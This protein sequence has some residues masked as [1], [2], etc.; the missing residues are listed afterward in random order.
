MRNKTKN[1]LIILTMVLVLFACAISL[2]FDMFTGGVR[3]QDNGEPT[4]IGGEIKEEYILGD[5][6]EIPAAKIVYGEETKDAEI[7]VIKPDGERI[8]SA[9]VKLTEGGLYTAEFKALFGGKAKTVNKSFT[10][11]IPLFSKMSAK[12]TWEYGIDDSDYQTGKEG[13]KVRL[14][15]ADILTY[16]EIIDLKKSDGQI[17]DFFLL[18]SGGIGTKDVKRLVVTLTDLYDPSVALKIIIQCAN[19]HGD[20]TNW[21]YDWTYVLA[22][23]Q[24]QTPTGVEGKGTHNEKKWVGGDWGSVVSYSFY[25]THSTGGGASAVGK[26]S[27]NVVYNEEENTVY[28]NG[29]EI[30]NL[31]DLKYFDDPWN[32]FKTG[33]VK[34]SITG[35]GFSLGTANMMITRIGTN[36]LK[37][38]YFVD[39]VAPA[40][41]VDFEDYDEN[42]L[43]NAGKG[44]SYPVFN[45]TA[46]DKVFGDADVKTTV[47]YNYESQ[48]RYQVNIKDGRFETDTVGYYT[49]EY[50]AYDGFKN[51]S[52]KLVTVY[53]SETTPALTVEPVGEYTISGGTGALIFPAEMKYSGGTGAVTTY[54]VAKSQDGEELRIDEGFRP[55]KECVYKVTLYAVDMLGKTA[56]FEYDLTITVNSEPVFIDEPILPK[57][58][59]KG[60]N[61]TLPTIPAYD[62]SSG[63]E[64]E[65]LETT[66]AIKDGKDGGQVRDLASNVTDF[67]ADAD[68][69]ATVIYKATGAKGS[70]MVEYKVRVVDGWRDYENYSFDLKKYFYGEN[71]EVT[72]SADSIK[73]SASV[74]TSY[75]FVNPVIANRF[76][77][78]FAIT[79]GGFDCL[80]LV[81]E[82]SKDSNV[83]FTVE[84]DKSRSATENA[85]LRINGVALRY[86]PLAGFNGASDFYFVYDELN[87]ILRDDASLKQVIT[88]ADGSAFEGFPSGLIYVTVNLIGVDR[89][90]EITWKNFGGQLLSSND[91]DTIAPSIKLKKAYDSKYSINTVAEVSSAIAA[92]V[93][94]PEIYTSMTVKDPNGKVVTDVNGV[95]LENVP[96][97]KSYSIELKMYGSY[98]VK[99]TAIDWMERKQDYSFALLVVDDKAPEITLAGTVA[100]Q[101]EKG[102]SLE[103]VSATAK[104]NVDGAVDVYV[105]LA[106][107]SGIVKKVAFGEKVKLSIAGKYQLRY[108][109]V[110]AFG[111]LNILYYNITVI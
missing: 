30:I 60:F 42:C 35:E 7:S 85:P 36:N 92:D 78:K 43:P 72:D 49:I 22:G 73:V 101:V 29:N 8:R 65:Q 81:F 88:N 94:C 45:A 79:N 109:A 95:K 76:E 26:E 14:A 84:I 2:T 99:Y 71:I 74:D 62:Y 9:K 5:F 34:M 24:N 90:A 11:N 103:V 68:G 12:T 51:E 59:L 54:A 31:S 57:F 61:Y 55:E 91:N 18:P 97:D 3:A 27:L 66:I 6:I 111:N 105:Y 107:A 70:N 98:A 25:G 16:N 93:L 110:D 1:L 108:L 17:I 63:A 47:Y 38:E 13:V 83:G 64:C 50:L 67:V 80:Q 86:R 75:T 89:G 104:D 87:K 96:F 56:T 28:V 48:Q 77:T 40:I 41:T 58:F 33:E 32:G 69:F 53:C 44:L 82:D 102:D 37:N 20:G 46:M 100:K 52:K 10:V 21:W 19:D 15:K 39:N 23:G 4:L 106:D